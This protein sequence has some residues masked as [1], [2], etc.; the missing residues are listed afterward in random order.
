MSTK[1][2]STFIVSCLHVRKTDP[3]VKLLVKYY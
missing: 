2:R 3:R 1:P